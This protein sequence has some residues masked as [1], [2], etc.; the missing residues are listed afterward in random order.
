MPTSVAIPA[1][2]RTPFRADHVCIRQTI[3]KQ[4]SIGLRAATDAEHRRAYWHF[5]GELESSD[6]LKHRLDAASKFLPLEQLALSPQHGFVSTEEGNLLTEEQQWW[7]LE[8]CVEVAMDV[9][10]S[11]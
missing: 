11:V 1:R 7:K 9:W 8:R 3:S 4:E 10:G 5:T 6:D 2:T